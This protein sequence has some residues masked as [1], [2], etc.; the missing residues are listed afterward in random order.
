MRNEQ[1]VLVIIPA[2]NEEG[3]IEKVVDNLKKNYSNFDYVIVNDGSKDQTK[4]ICEEKGYNL[5]DL[6][7]NL[8]LAG[9]FRAGMKYAYKR[10]YKYAVQFDADGQHR[11]E[12][13]GKMKEMSDRGIDIVI[14]SRF[15]DEKKPFS[16]RMLGSRL[17]SGAIKVTTGKKINDPTSGMRMFN[18]RMIK[19]CAT[20]I[21]YGP[22]PD[23]VSFL[24]KNGASVAEVQASMDERTTGESY[25]NAFKS[26]SYMVRMLLS[27][28]VIQN[29]RKRG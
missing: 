28:L 11:P 2:Y 5:I 4:K 3:S 13:I 17:I 15:V 19:E 10:G 18:S 14:A 1:K 21:N 24:I 7:I 27:I 9:G 22:E 16:M 20:N 8:G 26:I 29:F 12:Y 6:P 23:T 25:L